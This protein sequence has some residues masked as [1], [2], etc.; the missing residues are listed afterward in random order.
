[1]GLLAILETYFRPSNL[2]GDFAYATIS[3][4]ENK[5]GIN[6]KHENDITI[7]V[8]YMVVAAAAAAAARYA[9]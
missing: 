5:S 2:L 8:L 4:I 3:W 1:L 7:I 9:I 6:K